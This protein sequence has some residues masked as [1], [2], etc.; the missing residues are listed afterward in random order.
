MSEPNAPARR[1]SKWLPVV[2]L[3]ASIAAGLGASFF[4]PALGAVLAGLG[5]GAALLLSNRSLRMSE[6]TVATLSEAI[7]SLSSFGGLRDPETNLPTAEALRS[8]WA[9]QLARYQRR[10]ERFALAV[11]NVAGRDRP[12]PISSAV[13]SGVATELNGLVRAEDQVYRMSNAT[14]GVLLTGTEREG[15]EVFLE[16]VRRQLRLIDCGPG[17]ERRPI[18]V[19]TTIVE[20]HDRPD[21]YAMSSTRSARWVADGPIEE[22]PSSLISRWAGQRASARRVRSAEQ[23]DRRA[24]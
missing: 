2:A 4:Q 9:R 1:Y 21:G 10:G 19:E 13:A 20:W 8:E 24:S 17:V 15:A 7:A 18:A 23:R 11:L 5:G 16:R 3:A 22:V 14:F 6:G 12:G